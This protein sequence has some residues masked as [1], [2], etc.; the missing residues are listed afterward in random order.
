MSK[1]NASVKLIFI[2]GVGPLIGTVQSEATDAIVMRNPCQF[3]LDEDGNFIIRDYLEGITNPNE[4]VI[5]M[6]YAIVSMNVPEESI[7]LAYVEAIDALEAQKS[8][9]FVPDNKIII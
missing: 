6:K 4:P 3:G 2:N 5:F 1:V 8:K 9:V 7:A